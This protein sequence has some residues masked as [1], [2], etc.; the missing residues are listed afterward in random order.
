MSFPGVYPSPV[1][2]PTQGYPLAATG[3]LSTARTG[4]LPNWDCLGIPYLR[5]GYPLS[6]TW[7][8][9][10]GIGEPP[11]ET[12]VPPGVVSFTSPHKSGILLKITGPLP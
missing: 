3:I 5:L 7:V 2:G 6:G 12:G 11:A 8:P 10:T 4:V 1:T 9:P